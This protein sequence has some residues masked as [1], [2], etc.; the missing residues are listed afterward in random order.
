[1]EIPRNLSARCGLAIFSGCLYAGAFPPLDWGWMVIPGIVGLLISLQGQTGSRARMIGL[2][3][4]MA[5]FGLSLSWL[6][7]LFG[8]IAIILCCVLAVFT[9]L[10]ADMQG[11]AVAKGFSGFRLAL[12]TAANW[13]AFEFIRAEIFP[14]KLPWM[15]AGLAM[16]PNLLL[17]WIGVY[18][19]SFVVLCV[20]GF[21]FYGKWIPA[22]VIAAI[23]LAC[24][25]FSKPHNVPK[26]GAP[27]SV[28]VAGLQLEG[29]SLTEYLVGTRAM[30]DGIDHVVWPEY[31]VPFD[32]QK[33]ERDWKLVSDLCTEK[34]ITLT[35][36]T[37][38]FFEDSEKWRNIALTMDASGVRGEHTK[39]HPVHFFNDGEPGTFAKPIETAF[40][41]IGT[42]ICFDCDYEGVARKMTSAG[43][44]YFVVPTMDAESWS[45]RQHDQ[46]AQLAR[47]R[48]AENG[49]WIFVVA[50]SGVSQI[51][52]PFGHV[53][54][55]L[56]AMKQGEISGTIQR[57]TKLTPYTRFGWFF[58]WIILAIA[59]VIWLKLLFTPPPPP[60][61][62]ESSILPGASGAIHLPKRES[63]N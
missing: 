55:T 12:F 19:V 45:A 37:K 42:P 33:N 51:I 41:K 48:A 7:Y 14:L 43:A 8:P 46:H 44:E 58:P 39:N 62:R 1:M 9:A 38:S 11:R 13:C 17:P 24:V 4:G 18:G 61:H 53:H 26:I 22:T 49:R 21:A 59:A 52:D 40:G 2:L 15:S 30:P 57:E 3:H 16:G 5:A 10:F 50:T 32:I 34:N 35:F 27:G 63:F 25:H 29:V 20:V 36:G 23:L 56:G 6:F 31:S 54:A 60:P 47:I 28:R